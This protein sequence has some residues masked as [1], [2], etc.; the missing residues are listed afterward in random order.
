VFYPSVAG[1]SF[2]TVRGFTIMN[3]ASHWA[4]PTVEQPAAIGVNGGNHWIIE[5]NIV[6]HGKA[7]GIS[8]GMP[9]EP[10]DPTSSGHL[11]L[12]DNVI[13][14]CGQ[15]GIAGQRW[16]SDSII[17]HNSIEDTNY[18]L[19][20]GGAET[21]GIKIHQSHH[22]VIENN[23][24]RNVGTI[25]RE[26]A[27][28]DAI[29]L[30]AGNSGDTIRNNVITGA[31]GNG[32]LMEANWVGS[33][34]LENNVV[35]GDRIATYSSRDIVWRYNLF[36]NA[37]GY[38]VNQVDLKRPA[39]GGAMWSRNIFIGH[40]MADSPDATQENVYLGG[41]K[42]HAGEPGSIVGIPPI[43]SSH[44]RSKKPR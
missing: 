38:W 41:A 16:N 31:A 23:F 43:H 26:L 24:V 40:G 33:N 6:L 15:A 18:R 27:N 10:A 3:A 29:W 7:V 9:S 11:V 21:G 4:P 37:P 32:I 36:F 19:E 42:P 1:L 13:M 2:I 35:I 5:D 39:I 22:V 12:R 20:F 25:D 34:V 8:I 30:D 44:L 28:G 14:R 17:A